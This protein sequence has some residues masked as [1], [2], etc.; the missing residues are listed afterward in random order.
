[1]QSDPRRIRWNVDSVGG[2]R[3][4][5]VLLFGAMTISCGA[6]SLRPADARQGR[7]VQVDATWPADRILVQPGLHWVAGATA[8]PVDEAGRFVLPPQA[9]AATAFYDAD[10]DQQLDRFDEPSAPC[11]LRGDA[12]HCAIS[13]E[14]VYLHRIQRAAPE[15]VDR[16]DVIFAMAEVFEPR[17]GRPEANGTFCLDSPGGKC[18]ERGALPEPYYGSSSAVLALRDCVVDPIASAGHGVMLKLTTGDKVNTVGLKI[19]LQMDLQSSVEHARDGG[20]TIH[21]S[22][23]LDINR[24]LVSIGD[25]KIPGPIGAVWISES[26]PASVRMS[27]QTMEIHLPREVVASCTALR[28]L[29]IQALNLSDDGTHVLMSEGQILLSC[30]SIAEMGE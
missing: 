10:G 5:A 22:G 13:P 29:S 1:M 3:A 18:A 24:A 19:P 7:V 4:A 6:P 2:T 11:L 28:R 27:G 12:W 8:Q 9:M 14:R 16:V 21:V 17:M 23:K 15:Q 30:S 20:V 26:D 25:P